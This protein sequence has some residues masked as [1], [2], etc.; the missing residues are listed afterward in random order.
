MKKLLYLLCFVWAGSFLTGCSEEEIALYDQEMAIT[1]SSATTLN[2]TF[3]DEHYLNGTTVQVSSAGTRGLPMHPIDP[4]SGRLM[5]SVGIESSGFRSRRLTR[6]MAD[7]ADLILCFEKQQRKEI[8]TLAPAAVRYTFL[9]DDFAN[10]C[11]YCARNNMIAGLTIQER[12]QSVIKKSSMIRP[13]IPQPK[14]IADPHGREFSMFCV[15]AEQ[16]N[17]AIRKILKSMRKHRAVTPPP[18]RSQ[19][20]A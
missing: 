9:L 6:Q 2:Y 12:L 8:V 11:D 15:A 7:E 14:D 4:S 3:T 16:T 17:G 5:Q 19:I 18:I 10:M 1:F 13:M 20:V